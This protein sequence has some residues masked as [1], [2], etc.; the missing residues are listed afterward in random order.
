MANKFMFD[1]DGT[2][3][4][5]YEHPE[6]LEEMYSGTYFKYLTPYENLLIA[7]KMLIER[8]HEVGIISACVTESSKHEKQF[9]CH[10]NLPEINPENILLCDVGLNKAEEYVKQGGDL[11]KTMLIDDYTKNLN[12]WK[13][14]GG[15]AVK[16][17]NELNGT[18]GTWKGKSVR[19]TDTPEEIVEYLEAVMH[20]QASKV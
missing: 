17:R 1:L 2:T 4:Q 16:F 5:F 20:L 11:G 10:Y 15:I 3:C 7:I 19:Y 8:G 9:W 13:D 14:A 6:C 18:N 12:E